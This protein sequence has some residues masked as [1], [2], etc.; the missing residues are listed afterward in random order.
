MSHHP[1]HADCPW[2]A[3]EKYVL[4][5]L[6]R[7]EAKTDKISDDVAHLLTMMAM[8]RAEQ[9][10]RQWWSR[11]AVGAAIAAVVSAAVNLLG[12]KS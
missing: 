3:E 4:Q 2:A 7:L 5:T 12:I 1:P 6:N 8:T 9:D 10:R 11:A